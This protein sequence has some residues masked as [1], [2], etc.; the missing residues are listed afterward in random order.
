MERVTTIDG[1]DEGRE[2]LSFWRSGAV[3]LRGAAGR[4]LDLVLPPSC[5][6]CRARTGSTGGLCVACW[7]KVTFLERPWCERLGTPLP[8]D[9]GAGILSAAAVADPPI[10]GR[11]RSAVAYAGVVPDLV[12]SF[13]YRDR[14]DL[15]PMFGAWMARAFVD[16]ADGADVLVPIPL[17]WSRLMARRF[18]QAAMLGHALSARVGV[19]CRTDL[20]ERRRRTP[21]QVGLGERDRHNNVRGAFLVPPAR[22]DAVAGRGVVL[23]DDVL[24]TGATLSAASRALLA[25]GARSVDVMTLARVVGPVRSDI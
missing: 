6:A 15:A 4:A 12:Q 23:V 7:Q 3:L 24:T 25:A 16:L 18:N 11:A 20:L 2:T 9:L 10:F 14:T 8:L 1:E 19:P 5:P 17:H 22:R 13:K 21:R